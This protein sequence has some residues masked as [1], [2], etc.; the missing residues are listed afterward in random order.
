[1]K[2]SCDLLRFSNKK[3]MRACLIVFDKCAKNS[4]LLPISWNLLSTSLFFCNILKFITVETIFS[5]EFNEYLIITK[6][7]REAEGIGAKNE[8]KMKRK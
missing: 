5:V 2:F 4:K 1:M 8:Q 6:E 3:G 7:D